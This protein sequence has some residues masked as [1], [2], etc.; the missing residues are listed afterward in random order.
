MLVSELFRSLSEGELSNLSISDEGSGTIIESKRSKILG[1]ADDGLRRLYARFPL[2]E[3][4]LLLLMHEHITHYHLLPR[5]AVN[6][7]DQTMDEPYRYILDNPMAPFQGDV[8]KILTVFDSVGNRLPLNDEEHPASVFTPQK[9]LLQV[10]RPCEDELLSVHYQAMHVRLSGELDQNIELPDVLEE[11]LSA[12]I[13]YKVFSHMGGQENVAKAQEH[14]SMFESICTETQSL[15][16][17]GVSSSTSNT[18]FETGG[19]I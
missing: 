19:W 12:Y 10:P 4:N 3:S 18:R 13:A 16:S 5:F 17:V 8:L 6:H 1:Y 9:N 7:V 2:K 15:D 14:L 11:A